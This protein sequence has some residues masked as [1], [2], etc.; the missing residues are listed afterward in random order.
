MNNSFSEVKVFQVKP[1]KLNEFEV[2]VNH[3]GNLTIKT[4][5]A[6]QLNGFLQNI[7]TKFKNF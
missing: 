5:T 7:K 2:L 4:I 3:I 1:N 6:K